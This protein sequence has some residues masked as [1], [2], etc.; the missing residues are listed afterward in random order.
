MSLTISQMAHG[1]HDMESMAVVGNRHRGCAQ[2]CAEPNAQSLPIKPNVQLWLNELVKHS[3]N[4][5]SHIWIRI[6]APGVVIGRDANNRSIRSSRLCLARLEYLRHVM[7]LMPK[8]WG[9]S[10]DLEFST[11]PRRSIVNS[12]GWEDDA[13]L[14]LA[15]VTRGK[16][17]EKSR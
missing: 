7:M 15:F 16:I 12:S 1:S 8:I 11:R 6:E 17:P 14:I 3:M 5:T 2:A 9:D 4:F 13:Q 10:I